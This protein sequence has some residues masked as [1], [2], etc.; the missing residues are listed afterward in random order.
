MT[1]RL[2]QVRMPSR[3]CRAKGGA[4]EIVWPA[5]LH[6]P[7]SRWQSPERRQPLPTNARTPKSP[8]FLI[9]T[10]P[11]MLG[12]WGRRRTFIEEKLKGRLLKV[13]LTHACA[14]TCRFPHPLPL[15]CHFP[16]ET[17]PHHPPA[18]DPKPLP[19][20]HHP[21]LR[22]LPPVRTTL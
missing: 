11:N 10:I 9:P 16:Q 19:Q 17:T 12:P 22:K 1:E 3:R 14:L 20:G 15:F 7:A 13:V 5:A 21:P 18:P 6:W 4:H 8:A 2:L